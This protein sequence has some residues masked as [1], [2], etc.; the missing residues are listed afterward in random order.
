MHLRLQQPEGAPHHPGV[1]AHEDPVEDPDQRPQPGI[2]RKV[3]VQL[4]Q[5]PSAVGHDGKVTAALEVAADGDAHEPVGRNV[6]DAGHEGEH[7][8]QEPLRL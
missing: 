7:V 5:A 4:Q 6:N 1:V 3:P 8:R 2:A